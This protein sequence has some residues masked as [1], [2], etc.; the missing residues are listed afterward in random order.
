MVGGGGN[1]A[2]TGGASNDIL[3]GGDGNDNLQ[4]GDG[5]D[6]AIGGR[7]ADTIVGNSD[8]DILIGRYTAFDAPA[9][10]KTSPLD[11]QF[12]RKQCGRLLPL[13]NTNL[14]FSGLT[15]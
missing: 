13:K 3:I 6:V 1:D 10:E 5:R 14:N 2:I 7:G 9:V 8:D 11:R 12:G 15:A 4:G